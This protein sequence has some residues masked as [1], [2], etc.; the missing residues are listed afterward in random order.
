MMEWSDRHCRSFHRILSKE[1]ILY[2]EMVNSGAIIFG[3]KA[4][5]L[6]FDK[7]EHPVV[8]QLGGTE[9]EDIAKAASIGQ[10]WG[11]DQID[12]NCGCPSERVQRGSFGA[13]LMREPELVATCVKAMKEATDIPISVKHRLGLDEMNPAENI[14]DYQFVL[15][16][17][18]KVA[19]MGASQVTIHAR[20]AILKGLSPKENRTVPPLRY[21]VAKQLRLDVKKDFPDF[22][23]IL[24]G[25]LENNADIARHWDDFDG[26]MIGRAAY[27]HPAILI[28]WDRLIQSGGKDYGYFLNEN[29]WLEIQEK[30]ITYTQSWYRECQQKNQPFHIGSITRHILGLA[31]GLAGARH[32]R[33]VL[34]DHRILHQVQSEKSIR[35]FFESASQNLRIF[36]ADN[37]ELTLLVGTEE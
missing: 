12:L 18:L 17:I 15:N 19:E 33:Q 14:Q 11:Y 29:V 7:N 31:Y 16:F 10:Q 2:T 32:W 25:G 28:G 35:D 30:I 21:E 6:D 9:P 23:V 24:N 26:F 36:S 1:A 8:L 22:K 37:E 13:C 5:H 3:D 34:S 20:N 27:H 4:R